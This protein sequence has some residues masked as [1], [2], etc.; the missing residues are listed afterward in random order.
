MT[1][2]M[3]F[4]HVS[5]TLSFPGKHVVGVFVSLQE[6]EQAVQALV[7]AGYHVE[8]MAMIPSQ[9]FPSAFQEHLRKEGRLLQIMHPLQVTTDD[10]SLPEHLHASPRH[11]SA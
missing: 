5:W 3:T 1:K 6:A 11:A 7:D 9:D 8:D 10:R 4:Q 2:D